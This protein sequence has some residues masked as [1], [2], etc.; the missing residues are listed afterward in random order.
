[1]SYRDPW[2]LLSVDRNADD[3]T[4][5]KAY[6]V[7]AMK[8]HPDKNPGD[9]EAAAMFQD[10]NKAYDSIATEEARSMWMAENESTRFASLDNE[11]PAGAGFE[12]RNQ[13]AAKIINQTVTVS[14]K[15]AYFGVKKRLEIEVEEAC[16]T[17]G[18]SGAAPGHKP[19]ACLICQGRGVHQTG[20]V[21]TRC[22]A[23]KGKGFTVDKACPTCV[24]GLIKVVRPIEVNV[25]RGVTQG[26]VIRMQG[27][28]R[29]RLSTSEV[30]TVVDVE[31]SN[32]FQRT[33]S[34]PAD[35]MIDVPISYFEACFGS[36][37]KIPTPEKIIELKVPPG[38]PSG[39]V[40]RISNHGMPRLGKEGRGHLFARVQ[41][42]V[43]KNPTGGHKRA[44]QQL[45]LYDPKDL[46]HGL[47]SNKG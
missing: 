27:P 2:I 35:L 31:T 10:V 44:I 29:G 37:I 36:Y 21:Q 24:E 9:E 11:P 26:H 3:K 38:T 19:R 15:E 17:C 13:T 18:G 41:I 16:R 34:D 12:A 1:M 14:F 5:K 33:L 45:K 42:N 46:R 43:P 28:D 47:F 40:F 32:I 30:L 4:I 25:P 22:A 6:R 39:Y 23:C 7:L 20:Q 8:Y